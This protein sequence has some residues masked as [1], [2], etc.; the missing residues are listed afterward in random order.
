ML[1]Q[2][3]DDGGRK[4][5]E[6]YPAHVGQ[7]LLAL[8]KLTS[9]QGHWPIMSAIR[10]RVCALLQQQLAQPDGPRDAPEQ[11]GGGGGDG[12]E[13]GAP[14]RRPRR[15]PLD[16]DAMAV[17]NTNALA[18]CAWQ[19]DRTNANS[20]DYLADLHAWLGRPG[21]LAG[22]YPNAAVQLWSAAKG[23]WAKHETQLASAATA[24][25]AGAGGAAAPSGSLCDASIAASRATALMQ[26]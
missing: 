10:G 25:A 20:P 5:G 3:I 15:A 2:L 9:P 21:A 13:G 17:R 11:A 12:G 24:A 4:L 19:L 1:Q 16:L 18:L 14:A 22:L 6:A 8:T 7:L 26:V 23:Q